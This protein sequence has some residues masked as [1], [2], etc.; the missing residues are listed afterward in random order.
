MMLRG[1]AFLYGL[2]CYLVFLGSFLYA[3]GFV[4]DFLVPKTIDSGMTTSTGA[5]LV[6]DVLLLGLFAV[7]HSV[8]ARKGFK[9]WWTKIVPRP[10]ERSTYVLF[11]SLVLIL[12]YWQWR[13][14]DTI[15][16]SVEE[17]WAWGLL[18]A[19]FWL[20]WLLV[21]FSTFLI[22]HFDLFGLRQV[23]VYLN[24]EEY[25]PPSFQTP[26]PYKYVRHPLL[27]GF[28]LAFWAIPVMSL[29]HLLFAVLTTVYTFLGIAL[30]E[31]D[32]VKQFG[33]T[34]RQY[35]RRTPMLIPWTSSLSAQDR[36]PIDED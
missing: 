1:L 22:D 2:V 4:G 8:M 32:L 34:Y 24:G 25:E 19:I 6:I 11:T 28:L 20:G 16:W 30:E 17:G 31:R 36:S 27:L 33:D 14:L 13:P 18:W 7:Q 9:D 21:L 23:W 26:G 29:G 10:V 12:L 15:I 35:R 3:I 5:A